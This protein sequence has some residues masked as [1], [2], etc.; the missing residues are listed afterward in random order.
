MSNQELRDEQQIQR[1][2]QDLL[3]S[4]RKAR[5]EVRNAHLEAGREQARSDNS[6]A[7]ESTPSEPPPIEDAS[8][9]EYEAKRKA[10]KEADRA[11]MKAEARSQY[12][13]SDEAFE[14]EWPDIRERLVMENLE[15]DLR[16]SR[17]GL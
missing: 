4:E 6:R 9:D 3:Q 2:D 7:R 11:T 10:Q 8:D 5:G 1:D 12:E 17:R 16:N 13:G 14:H 15:K